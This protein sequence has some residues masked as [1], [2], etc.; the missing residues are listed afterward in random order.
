MAGEAGEEA[1]WW[2]AAG[3]EWGKAKE[4]DSGKLM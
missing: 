2:R 4:G 1:G 3:K